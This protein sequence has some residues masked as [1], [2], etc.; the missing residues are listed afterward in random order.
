MSLG[1]Q[2]TIAELKSHFAR[3]GRLEWIGYRTARRQPLT[4]V[5]TIE[6]ITDR[7]LAGDHY[8][9]KGGKRQVT[10][11]QQEHFAVI[12]SLSDCKPVTPEMLRR[13]L[14]ISGIPLIAL[15]DRLFRIGDAL[16]E[17]TGFCHPC[18][19]MEETLGYGGYNA[20]RGSG[21]LNARVIQGS[22]ISISDVLSVES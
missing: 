15:K 5:H 6:L 7:G 14:V 16:L 10:L 3:Q 21:G 17:G 13:N 2:T 22:K 19:R 18:S 8:S 11:I 20:M 4:S 12:E 1:N 9:K